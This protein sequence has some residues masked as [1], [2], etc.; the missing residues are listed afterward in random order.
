[1]ERNW[2]ARAI[3]TL[4]LII[5]AVV[6]LI[7]TFVDQEKNPWVSK[8]N[9]GI[10]LGLDLKG[11]IHFVLS[12][13]T[14]KAVQDRLDRRTDEIRMRLEEESLPFESVTVEPENYSI[15]IK[16]TEN[17]DK[18]K[19]RDKI[20]DFFNDFRKTSTDGNIHTMKMRDDMIAQIKESSVE[21]ALETLRSRIDE[22]GLKEPI[23]ARQGENAILIQLPGYKDVERA[24]SI[25]GQTAQLEFK[26]V[27]EDM[28]P[29]GEYTGEVPEGI[30]LVQG[31]GTNSD[32]SVLTYKYATGKDRVAMRAFL[33]DKA[34]EGTEFLLEESVFPNGEKEYQSYLLY[35]QAYIT[36]DMLTDARVSIDEQKNRPYVSMTFDKNG[37]RIFA[38]VTGKYVKRKMA[39]VLDEKV[40]SAPVIQSKIE[41]GSAMITLNSMGD[42]NT[43]F[44]EAKDLALVLRAG[45]L[46]APVTFE[47]NRTVGPSLGHDSIE[48]GKL[49]VI[50]GFLAVVIFMIIYYGLA[51]IVANTALFLNILFIMAGMAAFGATL[52]FPGIAGIVLTIG[53]AVDANVIIFERI[54]EE[55]R[56]GRS[57][58]D[59]ISTGYDKAWSA[60]LDAN[61]TTAISA[62]ILWEFGTGPIKGFA[63]TLLIGILS[64][65][66]TAIYV[67]RVI[68]NYMM[69]AGLKRFSYRDKN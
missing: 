30:T 49:S 22:L 25:I 13:D 9:D 58:A 62:F 36:G 34:P 41:G 33:K 39:I 45:S 65:M 60:I 20:I 3:F 63:I 52:T 57:L 40:N 24:R 48:A 23:V 69:K 7:P 18:D 53:M 6:M 15:I 56:L 66:F 64:S 61:V 14:E 47:E 16:I 38:E 55:L 29:L 17:T 27:A 12:V 28:D 35:R 54:K 50:I 2:L 31:R 46:P 59:A 21:Q 1:M 11:G 67:T 37:A 43:V 42:Y 32:G 68:F 4:A 26:I 51:G 5:V 19:F 8:I 44:E 10:S